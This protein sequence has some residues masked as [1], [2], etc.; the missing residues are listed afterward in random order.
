MA[1]SIMQSEKCCYLTGKTWDLHRHHIFGGCR[2][3]ASE[4]WGCWVWLHEDLHNMSG[5]GV[6]F[7]KELETRLKDECQRR[8]E[9]IYGH[10]KFMEVFGKNYLIPIRNEE[11]G[12]RNG[13][14]WEID[15]E[16]PFAI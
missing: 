11:L 7:N 10:E 9:A 16:L 5:A 4:R 1:K 8:F 13:G 2:R 12:M 14:F 3:T 6:H 15:Y